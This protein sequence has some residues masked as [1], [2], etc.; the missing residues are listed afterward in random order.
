MNQ[1]S[2]QNRGF[3]SVVSGA[4]PISD[5]RPKISNEQAPTSST[6]VEEKVI[7]ASPLSVDKTTDKSSL[8]SVQP[9]QNDVSSA[10]EIPVE[11]APVEKTLVEKAPVEKAPVEKVWLKR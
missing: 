6:E 11:K 2:K 5:H 3:K 8:N 9:P 10:A 7:K 4:P 1:I